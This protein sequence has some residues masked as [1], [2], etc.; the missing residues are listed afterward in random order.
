[1]NKNRFI[2]LCILSLIFLSNHSYAVDVHWTE[3][4]PSPDYIVI[5]T[6]I[7][8]EHECFQAPGFPAPTREQFMVYDCGW[9]EVEELLLG[10]CLVERMPIGWISYLIDSRNPDV[11]GFHVDVCEEHNIGERYIWVL[12]NRH[13]YEDPKAAYYGFKEMPLDSLTNVQKEIERIKKQES[14]RHI[15]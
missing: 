15:R 3:V 13:S 6:L 9:I 8:V 12:W 7:S 1:M 11:K 14:E 5:G 2:L 10:E 4:A